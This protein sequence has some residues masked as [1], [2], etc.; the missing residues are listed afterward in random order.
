VWVLSRPGTR[1]SRPSAGPGRAPIVR[2]APAT[3]VR[4]GSAAC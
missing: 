3:G 1:V 4:A 2:A